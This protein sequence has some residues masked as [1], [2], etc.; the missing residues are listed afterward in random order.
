M[1]ASPSDYAF[2]STQTLPDLYTELHAELHRIARSFL[3]NERS[4]HTLQPSALIN[5]A[6][7]R[8][9][10]T[11]TMPA[12]DRGH[13][14]RLSARAMR[15]VLIDYS[16]SHRAQKRDKALFV[17]EIES[18]RTRPLSPEEYLAIDSALQKLELMDPRQ[19]E[20]VELR[21]FGG[22]SVIETAEALGISEKTVKREWSMARAWLLGELE[23]L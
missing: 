21:F 15:Q 11:R 5:E 1:I 19:S 4:G 3:R 7:L 8:M 13:F 16:R 9:I 6:Y 18:N 22:L 23:S 12:V 17:P 20:I 14:L 10:E 2:S